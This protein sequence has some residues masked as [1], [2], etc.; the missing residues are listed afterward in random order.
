M[1]R[2][3]RASV[4]TEILTASASASIPLTISQFN[5]FP[6]T[7]TDHCKQFAALFTRRIY[8][9]LERKR[10]DIRT[11]DY[12]SRKKTKIKFSRFK[13]Q[14]REMNLVRYNFI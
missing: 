6:S 8:V 7:L 9:M 3:K 10:H 14:K 4:T 1:P 11:K 13:L 2:K 12:S 5:E